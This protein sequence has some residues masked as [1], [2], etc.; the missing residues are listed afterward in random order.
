MEEAAAVEAAVAAPQVART[1]HTA[2]FRPEAAV[3]PRVPALEQAALVAVPVVSKRLPLEE[4]AH[5]KAP[6]ASRL[7]DKARDIVRKSIY[8][9]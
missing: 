5:H 3:H 1:H 6:G 8:F 4:V 7:V 9:F 2:L